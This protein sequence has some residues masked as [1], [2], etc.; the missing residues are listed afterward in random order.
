MLISD[1]GIA[2]LADFGCSKQLDGMR[3]ASLEESLHRIT[4]SIPWMA[5]EVIRQTGAGRRSDVWSVG[6]TIIEMATGKHPWPDF[7]NNLAALFHIATSGKTPPVPPSL[8][9]AA[10]DFLARCFCLDPAERDSASELLAHPWILQTGPG[11]KE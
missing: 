10:Q 5:P 9:P 11:R 4:G 7:H 8:P 6:A 2:K 1:R 3:T